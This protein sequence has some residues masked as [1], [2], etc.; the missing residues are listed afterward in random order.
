[1]LMKKKFAIVPTL[2]C[3]AKCDFCGFKSLFK[4]IPKSY[5]PLIMG[6]L[7][8]NSFYEIL[9]NKWKENPFLRMINGISGPYFLARVKREIIDKVKLISPCELCYEY[10]KETNFKNKYDFSGEISIEDFKN[11]MNDAKKLRFKEVVITGGGEPL[12]EYN[13]TLEIIRY[14]NNKFKWVRL[15]TNAYIFDSLQKSLRIVKELKESGLDSISVSTEFHPRYKFHQSFI[16]L[17]KVRNLYLACKKV[18][19]S[20]NFATLTTND[21]SSINLNLS[22]LGKFINLKEFNIATSWLAINRAKFSNRNFILI[23][24]ISRNF[25]SEERIDKEDFLSKNYISKDLTL[26]YN[27]LKNFIL[28]PFGF[29]HILCFTPLIYP[30]GTVTVCCAN[31]L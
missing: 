16:Q 5:L 31:F 18:G 26:Y 15:I 25:I 29:S 13:K 11:A 22:R 7:K 17:E 23:G 20:L 12:I 30:N 9:K 6:S 3:P 19:L 28:R 8:E 14:A 27:K 2:K 24:C 21:S 10:R 1:M 4:K